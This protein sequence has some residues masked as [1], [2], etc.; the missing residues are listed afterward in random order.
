MDDPTDTAL[1]VC[2]ALGLGLCCVCALVHTWRTTR[3]PR[4]KESRSDTD[5]TNMLENV[6]PS[7]SASRRSTDDPTYDTP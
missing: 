4:M 6:I 7:A 3:I 1:A 5:L 2:T